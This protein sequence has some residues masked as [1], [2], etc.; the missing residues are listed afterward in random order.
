M[1]TKTGQCVLS[2]KKSVREFDY[3]VASVYP[4]GDL[5][6]HQKGYNSLE[7]EIYVCVLLQCFYE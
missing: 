5:L 6:P 4:P 7:E 1:Q 3:Q 2:P